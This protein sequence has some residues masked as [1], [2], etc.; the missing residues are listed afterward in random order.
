MSE[1]PQEVA[2]PPAKAERLERLYPELVTKEPAP[3]DEDVYGEA[4]P[5][6]EEWREIWKA[7]HTGVGRGL[8]WLETEERVRELEVAMLEEHGLTLPPEPMPLTGL[9][10]STQLNWRRET[11]HEVRRAVAWRHL[12]RTVLTCGLWRSRWWRK[13]A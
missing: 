8:A 4:W 7:G 2:K 12:V 10:R 13:G 3:D 5:L 9:W 11:L 1:T 6:I